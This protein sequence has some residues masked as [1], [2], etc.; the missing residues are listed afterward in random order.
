MKSIRI[1]GLGSKSNFPCDYECRF[2]IQVHKYFIPALQFFAMNE[3]NY[4]K[5]LTL[6]SL[7]LQ[8]KS[9]SYLSSYRLNYVRLLSP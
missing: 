2:R 6:F 4:L 3:L 1:S 8:S 7:L 9:D 5:M